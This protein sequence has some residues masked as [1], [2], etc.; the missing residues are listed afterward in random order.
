MAAS[1]SIMPTPEAEAIS[2]R[3]VATPPRV[4]S[5]KT[6]RRAP[7]PSMVFTRPFRG[8][9]SETMGESNCS[10]SRWLSTASPCSPMGPDSTMAS[11]TWALVPDK[12]TPGATQPSPAVLM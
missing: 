1:S 5:R 9:V 8:A 10:P 7:L 12:R 4:G 11:P 3:L 6:R 2:L